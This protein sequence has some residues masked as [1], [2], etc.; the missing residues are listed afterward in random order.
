MALGTEN[1]ITYY[2]FGS[3]AFF[4]KFLLLCNVCITISKLLPA[5]IPI[6]WH[7]SQYW[8]FYVI[9]TKH[10]IFKFCFTVIGIGNSSV[11]SPY[12][13]VKCLVYEIK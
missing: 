6:I 5:A 9:F 4:S 2:F 1:T 3:S 10:W 8:F 13:F 11:T 7:Y 12:T